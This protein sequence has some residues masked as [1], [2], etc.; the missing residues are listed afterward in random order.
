MDLLAALAL[1]LVIEGLAIAIFA[2]SLPALVAALE[3]LGANQRRWAGIAMVALGGA[4]Y[5]VVRG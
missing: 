5:L 1:M 3:E 2:G 4:A